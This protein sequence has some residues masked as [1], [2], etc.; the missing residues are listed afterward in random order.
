VL[1]LT[2]IIGC[3]VT[4]SREEVHGHERPNVVVIF[5][6]DQGWGDIGVQG[7][8]GFQ[9]PNID[10]LAAEGVRFTSFYVAQPVCSASRTA[11]L[12]GCYPNRLGIHGALGPSNKHGINSEETTL[13]ELCRSRGYATAGFGKWHLGHHKP[14]LPGNHGFDEYFGIPYSNDMW[15]R[16]PDLAKFPT[17]VEKR[18]R[19]YPDLPY[20]DADGTV[21]EV[22]EPADQMTF[23]REF[24][25][26]AVD[27]IYRNRAQPFFLY[28]A[29]PM[30]HVPLYVAPDALG[31]SEKGLYG[32][33]IEE[34]DDSV[35]A[36]L[37]ALAECGLE[38]N[39]FVLFASD[40]GPWLSYG[41]HGGS[42]GPLREGKG[43]VFEGGVRVPGIARWPGQIPAGLESDVPLMTIDILPTIAGV[44]GAELPELPIDGRDAWPLFRGDPGATSPHEAYFFYYHTGALEALRSGRWKLH[45]PHRYRSMA[46]RTPGTGGIPGKYDY[47]VRTGLELYDLEADIGETT[48][49]ADSNPAVMKRLLKLGDEMRAELGDR[50]T[51]VVGIGVRE[52]GRVSP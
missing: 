2:A 44:I 14:F 40:N 6:D 43:T 38:E 23:T 39:T 52:P 22:I 42:T 15:P 28:L 8:R 25:S 9:T 34:I 30:P 49:V 12:T 13:A 48:N 3:G 19:G 1:G 36:V 50:L 29:H 41:D 4:P 33:V 37:A 10:R 35:G 24:T 16:H 27:F 20:I 26:R 45:Y 11:L 7:A 47:D 18:R 32:D 17:A 5:T 46:G 51:D 21:Q 31:R